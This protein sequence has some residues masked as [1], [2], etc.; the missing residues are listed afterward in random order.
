MIDG[1][2][3]FQV[4]SSDIFCYLKSS[5][6]TKEE[7][8]PFLFVAQRIA[9]Q[10]AG[11]PSALGQP[12]IV[13]LLQNFRKLEKELSFF[14]FQADKYRCKTD[15]NSYLGLQD[16][17]KENYFAVAGRHT[18]RGYVMVAAVGV[19]G[20]ADYNYCAVHDRNI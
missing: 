19:A 1:E 17:D 10:T 9:P 3:V 7:V 15:L 6:L 8:L 11:Q 12:W 20:V 13:E 16:R 18:H 14:S 2:I 4:E 5:Y